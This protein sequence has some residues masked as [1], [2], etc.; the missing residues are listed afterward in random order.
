M[1]S[2]L[3]TYLLYSSLLT[4]ADFGKSKSSGLNTQLSMSKRR[5]SQNTKTAVGTYAWCAPEV[6]LDE[7]SS[8]K[9][10]VYSF[11]IVIW[12]VITSKIP[13]KGK[14]DGRIIGLVAYEKKRP[15]L[16]GGE[17][18]CSQGLRSLMERC[19]DHEPQ[20]RPFFDVI[21]SII[22]KELDKAQDNL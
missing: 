13:W 20:N 4:V 3:L 5:D 1:R 11:A 21:I 7:K 19:W 15:E 16:K 12:E 18:D 10:D 22:S 9:S 14:D 6:I 17:E 8:E 2:S